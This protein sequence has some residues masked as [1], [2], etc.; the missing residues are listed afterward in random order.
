MTSSIYFD[1][2]RI[3]LWSKPLA[4][5]DIS[6]E[7]HNTVLPLLPAL[8]SP[9]KPGLNRVINV[10][11]INYNIAILIVFTAHCFRH[12]RKKMLLDRHCSIY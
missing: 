1:E 5:H 8:E 11:Q 12:A 3:I 9:Q 6:M 2:N 7:D 10:L 4:N